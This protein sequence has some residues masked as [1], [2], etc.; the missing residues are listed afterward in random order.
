MTFY[1]EQTAA[2][3]AGFL[4]VSEGNVRVIRHRALHRLR[5][6]MGMGR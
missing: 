3:V 1:D 5:D 6:C 2:D 4:G